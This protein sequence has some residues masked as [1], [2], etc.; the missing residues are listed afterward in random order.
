MGA[1]GYMALIMCGAFVF[2]VMYGTIIVRDIAKILED[3]LKK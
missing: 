1:E 2:C 3:N